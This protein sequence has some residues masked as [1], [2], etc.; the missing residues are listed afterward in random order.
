MIIKI[1]HGIDADHPPLETQQEPAGIAGV[2]GA[3]RPEPK[4]AVGQA[5]LTFGQGAALRY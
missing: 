5:L 4:S 3:G 2:R 1:D